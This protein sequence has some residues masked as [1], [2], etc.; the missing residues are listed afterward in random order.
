[1]IPAT[2]EIFGV[3][4]MLTFLEP[5]KR[6]MSDINM[7]KFMQSGK[8]LVLLLKMC[9]RTFWIWVLALEGGPR[10]SVSVGSNEL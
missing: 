7:V 4:E 2:L 6:S 5:R 1:M 10:W 3:K 8:Y 9:F